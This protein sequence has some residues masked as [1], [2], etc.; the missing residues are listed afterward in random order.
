MVDYERPYR[1]YARVSAVAFL[2]VAFYTLIFKLPGGELERDWLHTVLHVA[3]GVLAAYAGWFAPALAPAR[4]VTVGVTVAYGALGIGGWFV[5]GFLMGTP[6][7]IPL[8][9]ADNAF[10][11]LLA[12]GGIVALV[13]AS[14]PAEAHGAR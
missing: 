6:F 9:V 4:A 2:L 1:W 8:G 5:D 10:H 14:R 13:A 11:A 3:T 7:R 12:G